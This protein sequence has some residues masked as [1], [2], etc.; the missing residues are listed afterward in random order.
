MM[1]RSSD[2][3]VGLR[4]NMSEVEKMRRNRAV[5]PTVTE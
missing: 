4:S 2:K 1:K 5:S 3:A